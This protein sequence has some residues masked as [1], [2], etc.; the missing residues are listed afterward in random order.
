MPKEK[1]D[2]ENKQREN[3][4]VYTYNPVFFFLVGFVWI[5]YVIPE[6]S[7]RVSF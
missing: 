4:G 3:G 1:K 2:F 7:I 6:S 5:Y